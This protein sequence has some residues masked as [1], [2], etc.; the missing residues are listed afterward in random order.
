MAIQIQKWQRCLMD[1]YGCE[2]VVLNIGESRTE[3]V[4]ECVPVFSY[5]DFVLKLYA[6]GRR[7]YLFHLVTT[8][9][10]FKSWLSS[11]VCGLAGITNGF[12]TVLVFGSGDAPLYLKRTN[13]IVIA[14][15]RLTMKLAGQVICRNDEMNRTLIKVGANP[16]KLAIVSGFLGV[17][18]SSELSLPQNIQ[19]FIE[20]HS[21]VLGATVYVPT[22]G[23][24]YPEYGLELIIVAIRELKKFYPKIGVVL[25]GPGHEAQ[26]KIA[27]AEKLSEHLYFTGPLSHDLVLNVMRNLTVFVRPT[28]TDGDSISVREAL[29]FRVPVVASDAAYRPEG[30]LRFVTGSAD[31]FVGKLREVLEGRKSLVPDQMVPDGSENVTRL[32]NI[33][34]ELN[35]RANG[36][37]CLQ[38]AARKGANQE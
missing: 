26:S 19:Q 21:P 36:S 14:L 24:L 38:S 8:G 22:T 16:G 20:R 4:A 31:D 32:Y 30:V 28:Y 18:S 5:I 10:S 33:Y 6:F 27:G 35:R 9:H 2:C 25:I 15:V 34:E 37:I 3:Q 13:I 12:K 23:V 17:H 7:G 29:A 1:H 11:L